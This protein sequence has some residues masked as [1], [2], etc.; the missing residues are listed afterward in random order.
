MLII[1][2]TTITL[3]LIIGA[4]IVLIKKNQKKVWEEFTLWII[5]S[6]IIALVPIFFSYLVLY[7]L[8]K[9]P[10][11]VEVLSAGQLLIVSVAIGADATGRII[12]T[13]RPLVRIA[14]IIAGGG[15]IVL[16]ILSSL[17]FAYVS[18]DQTNQ[19]VLE[20]VADNSIILFLI[21]FINSAACVIISELEEI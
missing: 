1:L 19:I 5:F 8:G 21:I 18:S 11:V 7:Y 13:S 14:R 12:G 10:S 6:V 2:L 15:C 20:N 3:A 16:I 4:Y 9:T 17:L